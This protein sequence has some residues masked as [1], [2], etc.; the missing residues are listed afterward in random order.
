MLN[1]SV[2][3][4]NRDLKAVTNVTKGKVAHEENQAVSDDVVTS[5]TKPSPILAAIEKTA[6]VDKCGHN[7]KGLH[8]GS[9][10]FGGPCED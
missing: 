9:L 1:T 8:A 3:T 6:N 5:V 2:A 10:D 4:V 7:K